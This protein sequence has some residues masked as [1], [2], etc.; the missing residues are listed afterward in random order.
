MTKIREMRDADVEVAHRI[1]EASAPDVDPVD[2]AAFDRLYRQCAVC[3]VAVDPTDTVVGFCMIATAG[4]TDVPERTARALDR[5]DAML[6]LDRVA[7]ARGGGGQGLGPALY[8]EIDARIESGAIVPTDEPISLTS[9]F[10]V[11]PLNQ[12]ALDFYLSR[13]FVEIERHTFGPATLALMQK[14]YSG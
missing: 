5:D 13:G 3:L 6:H 4:D 9:W 2:R 14:H 7:F 1:N 12:H 11:E 10:S 8:D